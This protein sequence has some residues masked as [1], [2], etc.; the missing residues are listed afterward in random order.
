[1]RC[2]AC[3]FKAQRVLGR[4][5]ESAASASRAREIIDRLAATIADE[6]LRAVFLQPA[7]AQRV[8][9]LAGG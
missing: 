4:P 8:L 2:P 1:M 6:R 7:K 9:L 3:G 5:E